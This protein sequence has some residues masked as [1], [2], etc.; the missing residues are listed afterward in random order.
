MTTLLLW[1]CGFVVFMALIGAAGI[2]L[3]WAAVGLMLALT[4]LVVWRAPRFPED[5]P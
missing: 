1:V 5:A 3:A 4:A 2:G